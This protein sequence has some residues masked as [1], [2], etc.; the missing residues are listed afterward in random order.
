M[1]DGHL[2]DELTA[3]AKAATAGFQGSAVQFDQPPG[4]REAHAEAGESPLQRMVGLGEHIEYGGQ[5]VG[6]DANATHLSFDPRPQ[7]AS[8]PRAMVAVVKGHRGPA[9]VAEHA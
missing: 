7:G 4:E 1:D 5:D 8:I 6:R 3:V 2:Y 9:V